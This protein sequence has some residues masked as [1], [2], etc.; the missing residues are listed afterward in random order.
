[1]MTSKQ[2]M[3][4]FYLFMLALIMRLDHDESFDC[5]YC[6]ESNPLLADIMG[7]S[8]QSLVVDC[9][10]C[11]SPILLRIKVNNGEIVSIDVRKENE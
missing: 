9:D 11:C 7:G 10:I 3:E 5:P 8:T 1:M 4:I 6:G 2:F